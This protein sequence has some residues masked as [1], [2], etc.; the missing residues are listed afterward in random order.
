[1]PSKVLIIGSIISLMIG[2]DQLT[3]SRN[4]SDS[5]FCALLNEYR[6]GREV[7]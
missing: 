3:L 7:A 5:E 6:K 1:M 2:I 4:K